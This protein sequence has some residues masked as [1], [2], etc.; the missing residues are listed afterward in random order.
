M[1]LVETII[2][3]DLPHEITG[4]YEHPHM[5]NAMRNR[6]TALDQNRTRYEAHLN[7]SQFNGV[8]PRLMATLFPG[9]FRKQTQQWLD[10]FK[11]LAE[12]SKT[13][14]QSGA[15]GALRSAGQSAL[16]QSA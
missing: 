11:Q 13:R 16:G 15:G 12:E 2:S 3:K 10:H 7:Y 5:V 9:V 4:E 6:F 14:A 1:E 8:M